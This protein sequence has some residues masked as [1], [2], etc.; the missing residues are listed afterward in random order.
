MDNKKALIVSGGFRPHET[1]IRKYIDE[2]YGYII[3]A[4]SGAKVLKDNGLRI[5]V[6]LGDFDSLPKEY[7]EE[8]ENEGKTGIVTYRSEKDFTDTEAALD[9]AL[10]KGFSDIVILGGTG[11]R[12]DH[13]M[14]NLGV[15]KKG[16]EMGAL[17]QLCDEYNRMFIINRPSE[18]KKEEGYISFSA[19]GEPV[20]GFTLKNVKYPLS[21]HRLVF[22]DTLCV[23][24]EFSEDSD[25][26]EAD[27][28]EGSVLVIISKDRKAED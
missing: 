9:C 5:D 4:D 10:E 23:S 13:F 22:G 7:L 25:H 14:A 21:D 12:Y 24:N 11:V 17:V 19:A 28:K 27:F 8:L 16:L 1:T 3:A 6:L 18:I 26:A 2:G 15:L 20:E